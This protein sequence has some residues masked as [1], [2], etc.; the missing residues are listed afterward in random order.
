MYS[1]LYQAM[2]DEYEKLR[3][4]YTTCCET[5]NSLAA[6][7]TDPSAT[8]ALNIPIQQLREQWE[9][10]QHQLNKA[11]DKFQNALDKA[12]G[13]DRCHKEISGWLT[14]M[15]DKLK[16]LDPCAAQVDLINDQISKATVCLADIYLLNYM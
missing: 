1:L 5:A 9:G 16:H 6:K 8:E 11:D 12:S 14:E 10:L 7:T 4:K 3:P 2:E 13:L 15:L